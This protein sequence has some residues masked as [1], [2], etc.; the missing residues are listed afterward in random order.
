M[1][2]NIMTSIF[3]QRVDSKE[4]IDATS[5]LKYNEHNS[6]FVKSLHQ[7]TISNLTIY[8]QDK[9]TGSKR[10]IILILHLYLSHE[11]YHALHDQWDKIR[12]LNK[13]LSKQQECQSLFPYSFII[14]M[15]NITSILVYRSQWTILLY[16]IHHDK[17]QEYHFLEPRC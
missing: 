3:H 8:D 6:I 17:Y 5:Y 9:S 10:Y 4:Q 2:I 13:A 1:A 7:V 11:G 16:E 15:A 14:L 12:S